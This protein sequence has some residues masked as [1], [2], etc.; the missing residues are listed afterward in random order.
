MDRIEQ[1]M[2]KN[3]DKS[4]ILSYLQANELVCHSFID[5]GLKHKSPGSE[6]NALIIQDIVL[7]VL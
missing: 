5:A 6:V 4:E 3:C 7:L 2:L 1:L